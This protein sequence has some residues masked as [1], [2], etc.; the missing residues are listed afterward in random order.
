RRRVMD[1]EVERRLAAIEGRLNALETVGAGFS[2]P[3]PA[4]PAN[5]GPHKEASKLPRRD[6]ESLIGAHWLNRVGIAAVLVG[7][8]YFLKYAFENNWV[9]PEVRV[10]IG[11]VCGIAILV[12]SELVLPPFSHSL[13]VLAVGILYLSIWA[14]S[15]M[16]SLI[17][18]GA[19]LAA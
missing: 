9:G 16:Y 14:A 5:A 6:L 11:V 15:E 1:P 4:G 8:A 3:R 19:A 17:G 12:W 18:G 13:K 2:R 10:I 7:A